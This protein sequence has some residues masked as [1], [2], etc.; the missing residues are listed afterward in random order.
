MGFYLNKKI[1]FLKMRTFILLCV[2]AFLLLEV[3]ARRGG[4]PGRGKGRPGR[5]QPGKGKEK[6]CVG[7]CMDNCP[8]EDIKNC[9]SCMQEQCKPKK[10]RPDCQKNNCGDKC[11]CQLQCREKKGEC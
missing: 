5:G 2:L 1:V 4:G 8:D 11:G 3:S 10:G 6:K 9:H 7:E